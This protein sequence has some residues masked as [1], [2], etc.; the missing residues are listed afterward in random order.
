[1]EP[2]VL[3]KPSREGWLAFGKPSCLGI[4]G[5]YFGFCSLIFQKGITGFQETYVSLREFKSMLHL[6]CNLYLILAYVTYF[7]F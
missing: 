2:Q 5:P 6:K 3:T 7:L 4:E 1:M